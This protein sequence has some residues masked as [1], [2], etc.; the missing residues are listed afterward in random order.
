M[1]T[2]FEKL[3]KQ[4]RQKGE[5][6]QD[7]KSEDLKLMDQGILVNNEKPCSTSRTKSAEQLKQKEICVNSLVKLR[8]TI[9]TVSLQT[10]EV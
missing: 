9:V 10:I 7:P 8:R 3:V 4:I 2:R 1:K 5:K 6:E